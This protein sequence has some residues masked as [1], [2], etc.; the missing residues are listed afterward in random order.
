MYDRRLQSE[1]S[2]GSTTSQRTRMVL[3]ITVESVDFDPQ[4]GL[5]RING[6][7][8]SENPYVKVKRL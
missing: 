5:L 1:S 3:T 8:T 4:V 6:R 7:V 2:T